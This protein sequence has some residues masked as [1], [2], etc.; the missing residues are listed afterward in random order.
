[1]VCTVICVNS[2]SK[3]ISCLGTVL[4]Q[5]THLPVFT[6][7]ALPYSDEPAGGA[8]SFMCAAV[9]NG[10]Y[11]ASVSSAWVR[12]RVR[13][14][15]RARVAVRVAVALGLRLGLGLGLG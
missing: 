10:A 7:N 11:A 8:G 3:L 12:V 6:S 15:V 1:M 4:S 9:T 14:R 2:M 13:V 5:S